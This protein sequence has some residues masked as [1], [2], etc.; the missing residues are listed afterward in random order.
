[1]SYTLQDVDTVTIQVLVDNELDPISKSQNPAVVDATAFRL[2]ELPA[3]ERGP[4]A[5]EMRMEDICCGAHGLSLLITATAGSTSHTLLFDAGP[6]EDVFEKNV[7]RSRADLS[8]VEHVHLSH[9]HR[10]HSGGLPRAIRMINAART[11]DGGLDKPTADVH[12]DRP[13]YRGFNAGPF[14]AS[15]EADPTFEELEEAGAQVARRDDT[16]AVLEDMFLVSG[17]VPR[18]TAYEVGFPRGMRFTGEG[19]WVPDELIRDERFVVCKLKRKGLVVF[20]GC[21]HPGIVNIC[22]HALAIG[23]GAPLYAVIGGFHLA[24][25]D[26]AK[27]EASIQ[28]L[29]DLKP[30]ILMP[31]H[32]TGW[33]FKFKIEQEIPGALVPCFSGT[34]YTLAGEGVGEAPA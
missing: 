7:T 4:A 13:I 25:G 8:A 11:A 10:D 17:E 20:A 14:I 24:D 29:Q 2:R 32:C 15:L 5:M 22:T 12:P 6:E 30:Q 19:K 1:M 23:G 28:G 21:S 31:G 9:W 27:L 18:K 3:G 16:H 33:R 26:A 34:K